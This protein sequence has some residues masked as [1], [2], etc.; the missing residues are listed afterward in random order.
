MIKK[1]PRYAIIPTI[2]LMLLQYLAY[3][4]TQFINKYLPAYDFTIPAFDEKVPVLTFFIIFY[5][6]SCP[7]WYISP[8]IV[9][10]ISKRKFY[11][12]TLALMICFVIGG[13][14]FIAIPTTIT[15]PIL[16]NDNV[17]NILTNI[18][19]QNDSPARPINLFPSFHCIISWFDY[20]G[21]R[22]DK[23]IPL[24][25]RLSAL[26]FAILICLSTQFVKQHYIVDLISGIIIAEVV[27]FLVKKFNW[28][29]ILQR[30]YKDNLN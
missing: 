23:S 2:V 19:Y 17:F 4:G 8:F 21:V 22:R 6:L 20:M 30:L 7:W 27:Y 14:I 28:G 3:Y 24:W 5:I 18:I 15:R 10:T 12:W 11:D 26:I 25:Y 13:I 16:K 9:A 29:R 1:I